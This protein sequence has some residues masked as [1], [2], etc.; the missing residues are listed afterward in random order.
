MSVFIYIFILLFIYYTVFQNL[1]M[2]LFMD[3]VNKTFFG[4]HTG[5]LREQGE[6][7]KLGHFLMR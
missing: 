4:L 5:D 2:Y 3:T 7:S 1:V 6:S